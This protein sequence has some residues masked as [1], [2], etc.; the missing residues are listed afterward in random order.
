MDLTQNLDSYHGADSI[1]NAQWPRMN[2][3]MS[4]NSITTVLIFAIDLHLITC[5]SV[6]RFDA[7]V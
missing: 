2:Y 1:L 7:P 5:E 6:I 3:K 4:S